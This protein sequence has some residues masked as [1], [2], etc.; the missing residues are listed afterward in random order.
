MTDTGVLK[1]S[2]AVDFS[3]VPQLARDTNIAEF[4]TVDWAAV[5]KVDSAAL[6]LSL[7][8]Q[9]LAAHLQQLHQPEALR[10]LAEV[11]DA[12]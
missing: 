4:H 6:A 10:M 1:L 11:Y 5:N 9:G 8:W 2:G 7:A 12:Q 3:T